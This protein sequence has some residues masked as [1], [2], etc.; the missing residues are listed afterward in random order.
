M[1]KLLFAGLSML[2]FAGAAGSVSARPM[3]AQDLA[4]M[5]R[6]ASPTVSPDG[7]WLA[8][9]LTDTDLAANRRRTDLWLLDLTKKG[10][11]PIKIASRA[12]KNEH[13][14]KFGKD[15]YLYYLRA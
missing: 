1:K 15:G 5:H 13:D 14:P 6:I 8:Y 9:A 10:A 12:D 11:A 7:K 2:A 3:T 4:T